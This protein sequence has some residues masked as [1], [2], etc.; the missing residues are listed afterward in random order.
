[1]QRM[2]RTDRR[3]DRACRFSGGPSSSLWLFRRS[4]LPVD[5]DRGI[6]AAVLLLLLHW[7]PE[8]SGTEGARSWATPAAAVV[9]CFR[10]HFASTAGTADADA[11][12]SRPVLPR[13]SAGR[14]TSDGG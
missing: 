10:T 1:M 2:L 13:C 6:R 3:R 12:V 11:G 8:S 7:L 4:D 9:S 5:G 14:L